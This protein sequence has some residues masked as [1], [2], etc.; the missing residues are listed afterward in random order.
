TGP[1]DVVAVG[2][3]G[4]IVHYDG[5][6]WRQVQPAGRYRLYGV[7]GTDLN[8]LIAVGLSGTLVQYDGTGWTQLQSPT[9]NDLYTVWGSGPNDVFAAGRGGT[10]LHYDG[11]S[12]TLM[13]LPTRNDILSLWGTGPNDVFAA[14]GDPSNDF[15]DWIFHFDGIQWTPVRVSRSYRHLGTN[16]FHAFSSPTPG[17]V[18]IADEQ[19]IYQLRRASAW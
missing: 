16:L 9:S 15:N 3:D 12:W 11:V 1:S 17:V 14:G 18:Y 7:W 19:D 5:V 2:K 13:D 4:T 6:R 8:K 10:L